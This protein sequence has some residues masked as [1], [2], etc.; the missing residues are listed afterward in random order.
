MLCRL[1]ASEARVRHGFDK[2]IASLKQN[3]GQGDH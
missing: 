2:A 3:L 1:L